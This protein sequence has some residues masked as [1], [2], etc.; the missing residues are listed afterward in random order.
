MTSRAVESL[1]PRPDAE[2]LGAQS[3]VPQPIYSSA[4]CTIYCADALLQS[5]QRADCNVLVTD[6]PYG[7][8]YDSGWVPARSRRP[9]RN[10]HD[11][12]ARDQVL[13]IWGDKPALVFGT[14]KRPR[15]DNVR[16]LITWCKGTSPGM[17]DLRLPFG[18]STE[19]IY[20]LGDG[21]TGE[22][23]AKRMANWIVTREQLSGGRGLVARVG[24]PTPK[25]IELMAPLIDRCPPGVIADPFAG[26][27]STLVAAVLAGRRCIGIELD[28][29]YAAIAA[30][31]VAEA[32]QAEAA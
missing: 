28:P 21:W 5:A 11:L 6:P 3:V 22:R 20:V 18:T 16:A 15:P 26:S 29:G 8:A 7:L 10:D 23:T 30:K 31:R 2:P 17:G 4:L 14:W 9:I 27:G 12:T 1:T 19:E 32:E 25:P 24:H 13:D